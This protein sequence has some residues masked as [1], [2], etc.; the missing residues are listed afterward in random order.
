MS[1]ELIQIASYTP[2]TNEMVAL[3]R[4]VRYR[5]SNVSPYWHDKIAAQLKHGAYGRV[6]AW[7][8]QFPVEREDMS[9]RQEIEKAITKIEEQGSDDAMGV[10]PGALTSKG[11]KEAA[12]MLIRDV[13]DTLRSSE[14]VASGEEEGKLQKA[15][16]LLGWG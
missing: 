7:L 9:E 5:Y 16:D 13:L 3:L 10:E 6:F 15:L 8:K 12:A 2:H 11:A 1:E 14:H 4:G